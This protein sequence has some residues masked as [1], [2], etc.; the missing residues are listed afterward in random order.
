MGAGGLQVLVGNSIVSS[1][2]RDLR[3]ACIGTITKDRSRF[4]GVGGI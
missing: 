1:L 2:R 3:I 4:H